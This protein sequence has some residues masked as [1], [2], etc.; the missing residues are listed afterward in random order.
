VLFSFLLRVWGASFTDFRPEFARLATFLLEN[1]ICCQWSLTCINLPW[2]DIPLERSSRAQ[3]KILPGN[4]RFEYCTILINSSVTRHGPSKI[5]EMSRLSRSF[6]RSDEFIWQLCAEYGIFS[7]PAAPTC[8]KFR[9]C[10][11]KIGRLPKPYFRQVRHASR[12]LTSDWNGTVIGGKIFEI[13]K[14][15]H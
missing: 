8:R 10:H 11:G 6:W 15:V 3:L 9:T 4:F 5:N 14:S 2:S 13:K 1:A 7:S 12:C